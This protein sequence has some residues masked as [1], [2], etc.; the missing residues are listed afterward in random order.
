MK[1]SHNNSQ[2]NISKLFNFYCRSLRYVIALCLIFISVLSFSQKNKINAVSTTDKILKDDSNRVNY[3][4]EQCIKHFQ[5]GTYDS[6]LQCGNAALNLSK[7][8][9]FQKG[10]A[11]SH[12]NIGSIYLY[13]GNYDKALEN[14]LTSLKINEK[15]D[16]KEGVA[17]SY[18]NIGGIYLNQNNL[19]KALE[20][21]SASLKIREEIGDKNGIAGSHNNIGGI[22]QKIGSDDLKKGDTLNSIT[23]YNKALENFSIS[24]KIVE[25]SG[26]KWG[27]ALLLNNIGNVYNDKA[28]ILRSSNEREEML[29]KALKNYFAS[30]KIKLEIGDQKGIASTYNN[31]GKAYK[32][33]NN[34]AEALKYLE[35]GLAL[36]REI[37]VKDKIMDAYFELSLVCENNNNYKKAYQYYQ[38]YTQV[39]DSV[40]NA[41]NNKQINELSAKYETEKK[42]QQIKLI[43]AENEKQSALALAKSQRQR[44]YIWLI[45]AIAVTVT[46]IAIVVFRSLKITKKQKIEVEHQKHLVEEKQKEIIDSITYAKRLQDAILPHIDL[47][48][49]HFYDSFVFYKPKDI[50]AGDFYWFEIIDNIVFIAVADCTGHGVPGA[51]VSVVCSNALNKTIIEFGLRDTGK[52]LDKVTD[53]V[54]E[55]FEKS[56]SDV[57]DGMDISLLAFNETSKQIQWSGANNPLWYFVKDEFKEIKADKEPVGKYD[58]RIPFTTHNIEYSKNSVFYL[59]TDGLPDQ[60][61]GP[62]DKKFMYKRFEENLLSIHNSQMDEQKEILEKILQDWKGTSEQV[63]DITVIGI[64]I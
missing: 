17:N 48:K 50:V 62:K 60:F 1:L 30:L 25:Q 52:I 27:K 31:I 29:N 49:K 57:K 54:I 13:Q 14:F 51:M 63:D 9:N 64:K 32:N 12:N 53:I 20:N 42:E 15:I 16:N 2:T 19:N 5:T 47:I 35:K 18:T 28:L 6:A 41:E 43:K 39:K 7:K 36:S 26:N 37:R 33:K 56:N 3:L 38:L 55:T 24:L 4:N 11:T 23:N 40:F 21:I 59:F 58:K 22:Y 10:V 61:G 44:L 45:L 34:F 8:I 46:I